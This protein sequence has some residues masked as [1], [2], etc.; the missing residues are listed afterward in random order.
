MAKHKRLSQVFEEQYRSENL[1]TGELIDF[2]DFKDANLETYFYDE[3]PNIEV[4][5]FPI[6]SDF[7]DKNGNIYSQEDIKKLKI[8]NDYIIK[9]CRLRFHYLP[10]YHEIYIGTTG[11]GKTT[12][13]IEPQ[14][15]AISNQ[16]NKP[17]LFI[18]DPKGELYDHNAEDLI[19]KGYKVY[20]IN[21]RNIEKSDGFNPLN[22]IY[23]RYQAMKKMDKRILHH[24]GSPDFKKHADYYKRD[25]FNGQSYFTFD[26]YC[27]ASIEEAK[28]YVHLRKDIEMSGISGDIAGLAQ[29]IMPQKPSDDPIWQE[30]ARDFL[31]GIII[32]LL[33][34]KTITREQF[35][36]KSIS[37]CYYFLKAY[38]GDDPCA[39]RKIEKYLSDKPA[40]AVNKI[41][42]VL[43]TAPNTAKG[44]FSNFTSEMGP[45]FQAYIFMLTTN[46]TIDLDDTE[47]PFAIF[48]ATRDYQ[49]SDSQTASLIIDEIY[50]YC[51][52]RAE[53]APKD[54]FNNP[55][56]RTVHF[57]LDEF[58]NI[59]QIPAFP[60]KI[61][62]SRSRRLYF[63]LYIQSYMQLD[64]VY[65]EETASIIIDNCNQ[66]C[67][68]G[69]QSG[70]TKDSFSKL[71]GKKS[72]R[73]H[74]SY[75]STEVSNF[76]ELPILTRSTLDLIKPGDVYI[77]RNLYN[78]IKGSYIR[79]YV[80]GNLGIFEGFYNR[81]TVEKYAPVNNVNIYDDKYT[82]KAFLNPG[83]Q[84]E[85]DNGG[86]WSIGDFL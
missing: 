35:T 46:T 7:L 75:F 58:G 34:D 64:R 85:E 41:N 45:W 56:T 37:D 24:T 33:A 14:I 27:F 9:N 81:D 43:T 49:E 29:S 2:K 69:S 55:T 60:Q 26:Q 76:V 38:V 79:S 71:C 3:L 11:S 54:E 83:K 51:L 47:A 61:A 18:T 59:P 42:N 77:K 15:R 65:G 63:H 72:V 28:A 67:F 8:S 70:E 39:K 25:N 30:G 10:Y 82:G 6:S 17:S 78:V 20:I 22:S 16:K 36:I 52:T 73:S 74:D 44:F 31:I 4:K 23:D 21:Y 68:L 40:D 12:G 48:F 66:Q 62:T 5:G 19:K 57:L 53:K 84:K 86:K 1:E 13:C 50:K 80:C 32:C